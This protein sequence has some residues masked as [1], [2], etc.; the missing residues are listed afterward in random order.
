MTP[1]HPDVGAAILFL[2]SSD[3]QPSSASFL[4]HQLS[5]W[6]ETQT[7]WP[8]R[9]SLHAVHK[10]WLT[11]VCST[12]PCW[13]SRPSHVS[14]SEA[15]RWTRGVWEFATM[16]VKYIFVPLNKACWLSAD[17]AFAVGSFIQAS[18]LS[19]SRRMQPVLRAVT[20]QPGPAAMTPLFSGRLKAWKT[21]DLCG[22]G[23]LMMVSPSLPVSC[24]GVE[25]S[26][27]TTNF[28]IDPWLLSEGNL[29]VL[30]CPFRQRVC[31]CVCVCVTASKLLICEALF[32]GGRG[33]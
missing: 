22:R 21:S 1:K 20:R 6:S 31:V 18:G 12:A 7:E 23:L 5:I 14:M 19:S 30:N 10:S 25:W 27:G 17:A 2:T 13:P 24:F 28:I 32:R 33:W 16:N 3:H 26:L 15:S 8:R 29:K 4:Y 11:D 9:P